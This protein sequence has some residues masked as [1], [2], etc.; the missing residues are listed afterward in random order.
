MPIERVTVITSCTG[1]KRPDDVAVPAEFL[2]TGQQ[3][4]RLMRGVQALREVGTRVDVWIVSAGHGVVHG[5]TFLAPYERTFQGRPT[6]ERRDMAAE[7][8]IPRDVRRVLGRS[9]ELAVMALSE[10]YLDACALTSDVTVGAPLL[11]VCSASAALRVP[12]IPCT[13]V[14]AL[15]T[16]H[17]RA[18]HCGYVGLKGE[19][20]GR[21]LWGLAEDR[22]TVAE[23]LDTNVLRKL[24]TGGPIAAALVGDLP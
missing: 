8:N 2:Y 4:V 18:F 5:S 1:L 23:A 10:E 24:A 16:P 7:L 14:I 17:T 11:V 6:A 13:E 19:V 9:A 3:H 22:L 20:V 21:L 15:R 12:A